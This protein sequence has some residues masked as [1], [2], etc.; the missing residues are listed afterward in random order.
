MVLYFSLSLTF[1]LS[2]SHTHIYIHTHINIK[3]VEEYKVWQV[4][5]TYSLGTPIH[6]LCHDMAKNV[7]KYPF[8]QVSHEEILGLELID[9]L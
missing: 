1:T 5:V 7:H 6:K 8:L 3:I 2:L 4:V 9:I